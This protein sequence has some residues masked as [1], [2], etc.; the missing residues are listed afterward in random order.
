VNAGRSA[1]PFRSV[2]HTRKRHARRQQRQCGIALARRVVHAKGPTDRSLGVVFQAKAGRPGLGEHRTGRGVRRGFIRRVD[3]RRRDRHRNR[4]PARAPRTGARCLRG[5]GRCGRGH[6]VGV[7][8]AREVVRLRTDDDIVAARSSG[9]RR[10]EQAVSEEGQ[11][12]PR[13]QPHRSPTDGL[14]HV[15]RSES[16]PSSPGRRAGATGPGPEEIQ[17]AKLTWARAAGNRKTQGSQ[18][19]A[20]LPAGPAPDRV[21]LYREGPQLGAAVRGG[22]GQ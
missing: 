16:E 6:R 12:H 20:D 9:R 5:G 11:S 17:R 7:R 2:S 22:G 15:R 19:S 18:G 14:P 13:R 10:H 4:R 21:V 1:R 3:R 8:R